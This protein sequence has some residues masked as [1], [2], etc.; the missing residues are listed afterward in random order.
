MKKLIGQNNGPT[1]KVCG[2]DELPQY[3]PWATHVVSLFTPGFRDELPIFRHPAARVLKLD[4]D[5]IDEPR[6]LD[7]GP[8]GKQYPPTKKQIQQLIQF[9]KG[10]KAPAKL[11]FH[12]HAGISR[13][14][15]AALVAICIHHKT[16]SPASWME[17]LL[18]IRPEAFPNSLMLK[19]A[20]ELLGLGGE[21]IKIGFDL[22][23]DF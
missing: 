14:T 20:D 9:I 12:C 16:D 21:L 18:A 2:V 19:Y 4:F 6:I 22:D 11:L 17:R 5:D 15:A 10:I 8:Y 23:V 3:L 1:I 7:Q 13:S